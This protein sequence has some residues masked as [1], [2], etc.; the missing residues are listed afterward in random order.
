M[1]PN[2]SFVLRQRRPEGIDSVVGRVVARER[3]M[4]QARV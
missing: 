1:E 4:P 3:E 2:D